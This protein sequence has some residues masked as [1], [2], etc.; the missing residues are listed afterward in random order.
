[1]VEILENVKEEERK[2]QNEKHVKR[3]ELAKRNVGE[4]EEKHVE[5]QD[6]PVQYVFI[7]SSLSF[8]SLFAL[9]IASE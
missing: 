5:N 3:K 6:K 9:S 1:M 7:E 4:K 8:H 2:N